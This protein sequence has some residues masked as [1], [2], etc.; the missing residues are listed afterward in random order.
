MTTAVTQPWKLKGMVLIACNCDWGCP[1]NFNAPPTKGHCEGGWAWQVTE[2]GV[3]DVRL[4]GLTF[5]LFAKWPGAIHQ[6]NGE[7]MVLVDDRATDQ[8]EA[9]IRTLVGG[10]V[11]GPWGVLGWTWPTMHPL[12][13]VRFD[14]KI[15]GMHSR[16]DAPGALQLAL[17][18]IKNP[19]TGAEAHPGIVLPEGLIVKHADLGCSATF[20]VTGGVNLDHSG[21]YAGLGP[22]EYTGA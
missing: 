13:R 14:V 3:G 2:G 4:D 20:T 8:Q 19:V 7:A 5:A 1:C 12:R 21:Q 22:F 15:D 9:A 16:A 11:G 6:G 10:T 18:P 17:T